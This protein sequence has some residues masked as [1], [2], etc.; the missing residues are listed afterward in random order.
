VAK[1]KAKAKHPGGR[2]KVAEPTLQMVNFR[3]D[4]T[5]LDAIDRL[6]EAETAD[7]AVLAAGARSIAIRRAILAAAARLDGKGGR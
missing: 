3:A 7:G 1:Q 5:V 6:A 4:R 2:P